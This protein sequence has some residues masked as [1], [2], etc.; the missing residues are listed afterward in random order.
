MSF[1]LSQAKAKKARGKF[2]IGQVSPNLS[3]LK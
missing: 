3:S 1:D 2:W